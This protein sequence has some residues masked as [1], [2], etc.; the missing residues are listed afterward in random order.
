M[1]P[2]TRRTMT[3]RSQSPGGAMKPAAT[4]G[5]RALRSPSEQSTAGVK[6]KERDFEHETGEDTNIHVVVRCR[7]RTE[8]EIKEN[9]SV[10]VST[11]GVRGKTVEL[12]MGPNALGN[13]TY[14]FDRVFSPAA[15]QAIIYEDVVAPILNE[16]CHR[17]VSGYRSRT[18]QNPRCSRAT[19]APSLHTDRR[20]LGRLIP[21]LGTWMTH[22]V[23]YLTTREL[24]LA[25]CTPCSTNSRTRRV[26]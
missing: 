19:T 22:W 11:E 9:S 26:P 18:N 20:E 16:V 7:G 6:R 25:C 17:G 13:K 10:V 3:D 4:S 15:D 12:S 21:C 23:S 14:H 2:T 8:R 1:R 24:S 5:A